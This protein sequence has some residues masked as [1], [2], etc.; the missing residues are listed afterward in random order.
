MKIC[1]TK[2]SMNGR[3]FCWGPILHAMREKKQAT[4]SHKNSKQ[5]TQT[6]ERPNYLA[7]PPKGRINTDPILY[8]WFASCCKTYNNLADLSPPHL[9]FISA[10]RHCQPCCPGH[11]VLQPC[12]QHCSW[13]LQCPQVC[14]VIPHT[15]HSTHTA[16]PSESKLAHHYLHLIEMEHFSWLQHSCWPPAISPDAT[17]ILAL[18]ME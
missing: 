14:S 13:T 10:C 8:I 17:L 7:A 6:A 18:N 15:V 2:D 9:P 16:A 5:F 11:I 12:A 4:D 1:T 3:H